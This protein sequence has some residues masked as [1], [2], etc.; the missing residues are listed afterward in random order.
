MQMMQNY[1]PMKAQYSFYLR[2][3]LGSL[4][5]IRPEMHSDLESLLWDSF[6]HYRSTW[7]TMLLHSCSPQT[8][9]HDQYLVNIHKVTG[10]RYGHDGEDRGMQ[11]RWSNG[12][13]YHIM[14]PACREIQ[15]G[16]LSMGLAIITVAIISRIACGIPNL[17]KKKKK[18][19][20]F[21]CL[22]FEVL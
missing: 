8:L 1:Q 14:S 3:Y 7:H 10:Y 12:W 16:V 11:I 2:S 21:P 20:R 4:K 13:I 19:K 22:A 9:C 5:L 18:K 15:Q 6:A 17:I